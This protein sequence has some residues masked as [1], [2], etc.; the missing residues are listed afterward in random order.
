MRHNSSIGHQK[1]LM[2]RMRQ[3][4]DSELKRDECIEITSTVTREFVHSD[5]RANKPEDS[6]W[7]QAVE[8]TL[9]VE[10]D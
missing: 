3:D 4:I 6:D 9:L 2:L 1:T 8:C 7:F 10:Y 5:S